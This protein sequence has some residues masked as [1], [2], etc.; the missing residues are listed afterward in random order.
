VGAL[1]VQDLG[2][3]RHISPATARTSNVGNRPQGLENLVEGHFRV[4]LRSQSL[5]A[6][7]ALP[8][9]KA[10]G[11]AHQHIRIEGQPIAYHPHATAWGRKGNN[12]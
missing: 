11:Y 5:Q 3:K 7:A 8:R 9:A 2:R 1:A 10:A 6:V 4:K 12:C